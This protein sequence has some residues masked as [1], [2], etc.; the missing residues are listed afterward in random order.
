MALLLG[1]PAPLVALRC[2]TAHGAGSAAARAAALMQ[3]A[4]TTSS[5]AIISIGADMV[6]QADEQ[7]RSMSASA[8]AGPAGRSLAPPSGIIEVREYSL[9]ASGFTAFI[10]ASGDYDS[11]RRRHYNM[12]G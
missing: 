1:L 11:V 10:K 2:G 5:A 8:A 7:R 3:A 9:H 6:A 12:V 4:E